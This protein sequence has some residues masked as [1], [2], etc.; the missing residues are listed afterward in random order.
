V[1]HR[2]YPRRIARREAIV[3]GQ[4]VRFASLRD[5]RQNK[6]LKVDIVDANSYIDQLNLILQTLGTPSDETVNRVASEKVSAPAMAK[7][8][9]IGSC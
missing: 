1:V 7:A 9:S 4:G 3:Q 2:L 8:G 5:D 6:Q